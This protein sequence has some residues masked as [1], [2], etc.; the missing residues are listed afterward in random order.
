[1]SLICPAYFNVMFPSQSA[2]R[3]LL[4]PNKDFIFIMEWYKLHKIGENQQGEV[5]ER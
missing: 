5:C 1:M 4:H 2:L 3:A